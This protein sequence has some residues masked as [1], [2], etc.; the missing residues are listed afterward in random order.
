VAAWLEF[1][2]Q[3]TSEL[4]LLDVGEDGGTACSTRNGADGRN[5]LVAGWPTTSWRETK[6]DVE[7]KLKRMRGLVLAV[8]TKGSL[9]MV[10][11]GLQRS[12]N[13]PSYPVVATQGSTMGSP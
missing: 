12:S 10:A 7:V 3:T 8:S 13:P 4:P 5:E 9:F 6:G 1:F 11:A 2:F